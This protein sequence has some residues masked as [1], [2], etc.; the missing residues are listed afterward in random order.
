MQA[1][2]SSLSVG[3][4]WWLSGLRQT[5]IGIT[6]SCCDCIRWNVNPSCAVISFFSALCVYTAKCKYRWISSLNRGFTNHCTGLTNESSQTMGR[7]MMFDSFLSVLRSCLWRTW[8]LLSWP[9]DLP[10][11]SEI[12][13][14]LLPAVETPV[15]DCGKVSCSRST[16]LQRTSVLLC[17]DS[18]SVF[19]SSVTAKY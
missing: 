5:C 2:V 14:D 15:I 18:M 3:L 10:L 6:D 19:L 16:F 7:G 17:S 11:F 12:I 4:P 13:Q 8:T 9:T 1:A